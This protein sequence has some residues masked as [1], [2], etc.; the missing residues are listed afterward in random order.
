MTAPPI[1]RN[2]AKKPLICGRRPDMSMPFYVLKR[3][4]LLGDAAK[5][6]ARRQHFVL[7]NRAE[8]EAALKKSGFAT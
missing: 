7:V 3:L 2:A 6:D 4:G 5:D 8:T 1:K